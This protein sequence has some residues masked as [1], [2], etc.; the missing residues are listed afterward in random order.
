MKYISLFPLLFVVFSAS[1]QL[2]RPIEGGWFLPNGWSITPAGEHLPAKDA[3]LNLAL[4]PDGKHMAALSCGYNEHEVLLIDTETGKSVQRVMLPTAWLGLAWAPNGETLY[5]SGGNRKQEKAEA[6]PVFAIPFKNGKLSK[7]KILELRDTMPRAETF[8]SGLVHH[9]SK[10]LLYAA[11]RMTGEVVIFDTQIGAV[12]GR[13]KVERDPYDLVISAD[14]ANLYCSNWGSDSLSVIDLNTNTL[15]RTVAAGDNPN[16]M[17]LLPDGRLFVCSSNDNSVLC[18]DTA[19]MR[20]TEKVVTSLHPMAPEGSTPNALAYDPNTH[21]LYVANADNYNVCVINVEDAGEST[22]LG[23][24]PA[25]WYPSSVALSQDGRN[26]YVGNAKGLGSYANPTGPTRP[27]KVGDTA[28]DTVKNLM[29][30]AVS[31]VDLKGAS[32]TAWTEQCMKNCP[33]NDTLLSAAMVPASP[34]VVPREV[35]KGSPVKH[36]LYIIKENRTYDQVY[37]DMPEGNGDPSLCLFG[38]E[39]TPNQHKLAREFVLLDNLYCD[40][41]V[42]VDG[43]LWTVGAYATDFAEKTWPADYGGHL[44]MGES[45]AMLPHSGFIWDQAAAKGITYRNYGEF[46]ERQSDGSSMQPQSEMLGSLHGHV[47]PNYLSWGARDTENAKEFIREFDEFEKNFDSADPA[48]RLPN[49]MVL[50]L[51]EDHTVGTKPGL[52]TPRAAVASN[53]L[54][55]GQI[56]ERVSNS[57]YWPETAI[58]VIQDDAQDGSDH[59]DA[60]RTIGQCISPYTRRGTVDS[61]MYTTSSMLRTIELLLGLQPMS[62]FDAAATP[63]YASLGDTPDFKPFQS[64]PAKIDINEL[65]EEGNPGAKASLE[66]D[67]SDYDRTPMY[68]L[69]EVIWKSIKGADSEMPLPVHRFHPDDPLLAMSR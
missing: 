55:L 47:A 66:M 50:A 31:I 56:V 36:V 67:F 43:H 20:F 14:G 18:F 44:E 12:S 27:R 58:F 23:F 69:N 32:L 37:G 61:T 52:P 34:S 21:D 48:L 29:T 26:L 40:A 5:V 16:D 41:E 10:P 60:R 46:A 4:S 33:Y 35:G 64:V 63:L 13:V 57:R 39:V 2:P 1:A 42:S 8:W 9:P 51:P 28:N 19:Q 59:V 7:R 22:V 54:A 45:P 30:G 38:E 49:L 25:G 15:L 3:V 62:Q 65:N 68:A 6:A 17:T 53:D 11:S 24:I